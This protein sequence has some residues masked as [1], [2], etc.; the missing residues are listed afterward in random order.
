MRKSFWLIMLLLVLSVSIFGKV[1]ITA[2]VWSWDLEK[3]K[4]I[5]A[6]FTK[7]YPDIEVQFVVNEPDVNGFLTAQ[8]AA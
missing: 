8:V 2:A 5:A 7:I 4:K 1:T 3:Y 6:E